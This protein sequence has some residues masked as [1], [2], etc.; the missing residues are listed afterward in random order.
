MNT[1]QRASHA[2]L[3]QALREAVEWIE[4]RYRYAGYKAPPPLV[5][6]ARALLEK[7]LP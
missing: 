1:K 7:E 3:V 5:D 2:E 6:R 4:S